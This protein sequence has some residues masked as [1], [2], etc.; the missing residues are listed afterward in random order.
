[1]VVLSRRAVANSSP[2]SKRFDTFAGPVSGSKALVSYADVTVV[3]CLTPPPPP[4]PPGMSRVSLA[5]RRPA[6]ENWSAATMTD[7][8]VEFPSIAQMEDERV[9]GSDGR[10]SSPSR[11]RVCSTRRIK[12]CHP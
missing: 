3:F 1:V 11:M 4:Q 7:P 10:C 8:Y 5:H 12:L 6:S 2:T 9:G